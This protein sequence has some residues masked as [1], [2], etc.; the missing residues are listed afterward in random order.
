M[1]TI[2][3]MSACNNHVH[4]RPQKVLLDA[5]PDTSSSVSPVLFL[6]KLSIFQYILILV[7][8][9][10]IQDTV[11]LFLQHQKFAQTQLC[12]DFDQRQSGGRFAEEHCLHHESYARAMFSIRTCMYTFNIFWVVTLL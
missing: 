5:P 3:N 1:H 12:T 7:G 6:L 4:K 11:N 9:M 8:L 10:V 2:R